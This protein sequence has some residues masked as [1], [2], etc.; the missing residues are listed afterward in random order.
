MPFVPGFI[1]GLIKAIKDPL[2]RMSIFALSFGSTFIAIM[3]VLSMMFSAARHKTLIY[4]IG[5][6]FFFYYIFNSKRAKIYNIYA[7]Y[8]LLGVL[9]VFTYIGLKIWLSFNLE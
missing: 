7:L 1:L 3:M 8:C 9:A 6:L 4:P 5:V 2:K